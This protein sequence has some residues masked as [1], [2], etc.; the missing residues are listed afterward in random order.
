MANKGSLKRGS[1]LIC[2][3]HLLAHKAQ[4]GVSNGCT[5]APLD[6]QIPPEVWC[7]RCVFGVQIPSHEVFGC[8]GHVSDGNV[9]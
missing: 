6:I 9:T 4:N 5:D 2:V 7:F 8:L 3:L 1:V